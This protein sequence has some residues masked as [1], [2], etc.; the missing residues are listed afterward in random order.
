MAIKKGA[1][2]PFSLQTFKTRLDARANQ[3]SNLTF[4]YAHPSADKE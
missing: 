3:L 1:D 2:A 4:A